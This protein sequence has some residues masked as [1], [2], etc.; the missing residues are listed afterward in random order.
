MNEDTAAVIQRE[1]EIVVPEDDKADET[2]SDS[3]SEDENKDEVTP[4]PDGENSQDEDKLPFHK[5][6][7]WT[8]RE[9][10]WTK[11]FNE[12]EQRHQDDLKAIREEFKTQRQ[13]NAQQ[14]KIPA[15]FGGT[16]EQWDAYRADRDAELKAAAD[17]AIER[18]KSEHK[19]TTETETKAVEE[20]TK[21][22]N[23]EVAAIETDKTLNPTGAKIDRAALLKIVVDNELVDTKGRWNYRA[24]IRILNAGQKPAEVKKDPK[25]ND[26]KVIA[27]ATTEREGKGDD[28]KPTYATSEDFKGSKRPW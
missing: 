11:R 16:Q 26:R 8:K 5:H 25:D 2:P 15:W 19:T 6:P 24:G 28:K 17:G 23:E 20:A 22:L 4:S 7:R 21:F 14:T 18:L 12:Q 13:D 27:A 1:G 3:H 9:D 10:E